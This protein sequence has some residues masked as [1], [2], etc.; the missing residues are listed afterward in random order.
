MAAITGAFALAKALNAAFLI[1]W[2]DFVDQDADEEGR[3]KRETIPLNSIFYPPCFQWDL[4]LAPQS[5][6]DHS[7]HLMIDMTF[8]GN[9]FSHDAVVNGNSSVWQGH[10]IIRVKCWYDFAPLVLMNPG[11]DSFSKSFPRNTYASAREPQI[12]S[13][14]TLLIRYLFTPNIQTYGNSVTTEFQRLKDEVRQNCPGSRFYGL[15]LR[16][17]SE[18][19]STEN[20]FFPCLEKLSLFTGDKCYF[21]ASD[22]DNTTA[23]VK[24]HLPAS[25]RLLFLNIP[26]ERNTAQGLQ[27]AIVELYILSSSFM[28]FG[29]SYSSFVGVAATIQ[30]IPMNEQHCYPGASTVR[31]SVCNNPDLLRKFVAKGINNVAD[32]EFDQRKRLGCVLL[33]RHPPKDA[34]NVVIYERKKQPVVKACLVYVVTDVS[35][36]NS[37]L[38]SIRSLEG[39]FFGTIK[40]TYRIIVF[41]QNISKDQL[42]P[43]A[44]VREK[45]DVSVVELGPWIQ[46]PSLDMDLLKSKD[47]ASINRSHLNW[48]LCGPLF[49]HPELKGYDY[50]MRLDAAAYLCSPASAD[51]FQL[52]VSRGLNY[53]SLHQHVAD[54]LPMTGLDG[55]T[56]SFLQDNGIRPINMHHNLNASGHLAPY[57]YSDAYEV[58]R[59]EFFLHSK[60]N[61]YFEALDKANGFFTEGWDE[62]VIKHLALK[63]FANPA[64]ESGDYDNIIKY[65]K[66]CPKL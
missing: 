4:A 59:L 35:I 63:V 5:V 36:I 25:G 16:L 62:G 33:D 54:H 58:I 9:D 57:R 24:P 26:R 28:I 21:I 51:P 47:D 39:Y 34:N 55:L 20:S 13:P 53:A 65:D 2:E 41:T 11:F 15:H 64:S 37:L 23:T 12:P 17:R 38:V 42:K 1:Q 52:M 50:I 56:K 46:P 27:A 66:Y 60:Y 31:S 3:Q 19:A 14:S 29:F 40:Q 30:G 43:L 7:A 18:F 45:M 22:S 32:N 10:Q 44:E 61:D 49:K 48:F 8:N 6:R